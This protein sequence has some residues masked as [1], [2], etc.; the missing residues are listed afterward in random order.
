MDPATCRDFPH[1]G[2][3][4]PLPACGSSGG[5]P[6]PRG[7]A[8]AGGRALWGHFP[9]QSPVT[10]VTRPGGWHQDEWSWKPV[11]CPRGGHRD[12]WSW[13]AL[14]A[15]RLLRTVLPSRHG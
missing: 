8:G 15:T 3:R 2:S 14:L 9:T 6:S 13:P 12:E 11:T 1:P 5:R 10:P 4:L 7:G